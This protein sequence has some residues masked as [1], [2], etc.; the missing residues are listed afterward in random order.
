MKK[1][2]IKQVLLSIVL[3]L[4][5]MIIHAQ[6]FN[7]RGVVVDE[8]NEKLPG[9]SV[10]IKNTLKGTE[11]DFDGA[12]TLKVKKGDILSIS[13]LGY[14]TQEVV[15]TSQKELLISLKQDANVLEEVVVTALGR[16][17]KK[18]AL[19]FA[20]ATVTGENLVKT[21]EVD[22]N[23]SI[24][25]KV[26]GVQAIGSSGATFDNAN[27]RLRGN[28]NVLYVVDGVRVQ[29][30][31]DI[32]TADIEDISV[33]KGGAATALYGTDASGG[34][35][36][37]TSKKAR[38]GSKIDIQLSTEI[39]S[40]T[41]MLE[42]QN[43]YGGGYSQDFIVMPNG[44]LRPDYGADQSWGPRLDGTLV[45]HWDSW[46]E[47][48]PEFGKLRPWS[49]NPT[50]VEDFYEN[51][52]IKKAI[53]T[54]QNGGENHSISSVL[55]HVD[56]E[57]I[58]PNSG[59]KTTQVSINADY[60]VTPKLKVNANVNYQVRN[61]LNNP[62]LGYTG[63][64]SFFRPNQW[65]QRQLDMNR[66]RNY[67]RNGKFVSWNIQSPTNPI[68]AFW[69]SPY[70]EFFENRNEQDKNA[71]F[72]K[73]AL[74]YNILENLTASVQYRRTYNA[75]D[76]FRI[77][78]FGSRGGATQPRF[79]ESTSK[80]IE[81]EFFGT[82]NYNT[83]LGEEV[84]LDATVGFQIQNKKFESI[85]A[86]TVGGLTTPN[87]Y[88]IA[89]SV[90]RPTYVRNL[91][92]IKGRALFGSVT[93]SFKDML[94]IDTSLRSDWSSTANPDKN[95]VITYGVSSSFVFSE[96]LK[97]MDFLNFGKLRAGFSSAPTFP[98]AH[99]I[100]ETY[101]SAGNYNGLPLYSIPST[102][103]NPEI[104]G[105]SSKEAEFGLELK[106]FN[107]K[108]DFDLTY[109]NIVANDFPRSVS[110]PAS[111][112][113]SSVIRNSGKETR[114][115]WELGMTFRPVKTEDF[116][117]ETTVNLATIDWV[118]DEINNT[119]DPN[120]P[121]TRVLDRVWT[122]NTGY[123]NLKDVEGMPKGG[124]YGARAKR[125]D[126][127]RLIINQS[128]GDW[129][130]QLFEIENDVL[131][132]NFLPDLTG[133]FVNTFRYKDFELAASIDFQIGGEFYSTSKRWAL[134]SGQSIETVGTN[135]KGNPI[136]DAVADG[137]GIRVDGV[138]SVTGEPVTRYIG[139]YAYFDRQLPALAES[140]VYDASYVK[141]RQMSIGYTLPSKWYKKWGISNVKASIFG[142]NLWLIYAKDEIDPS[143][144]EN[145]SGTSLG[146]NGRGFRWQ[147]GAQFPSQRTIGMNVNITF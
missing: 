102:Q 15:I 23:N 45:R 17:K 63:S 125:D 64:G 84:G 72:G 87:F 67:K 57:G 139:A 9:V 43:E 138:D 141:L 35:V 29:S 80:N 100:F 78:A 77:Q 76:F 5:P 82:L 117:W 119:D 132:G 69:D 71:V 128:A 3:L 12:F 11:T 127:G 46:I 52:F 93:L 109:Y 24:A 99:Q 7:I 68:P 6:E 58:L 118:V 131:L 22:I 112:G 56:Q 121:S 140:L 113:F 8:L 66:L 47:G 2:K 103:K 59:R 60:N 135:D 40:V 107:N 27:I 65:W 10:L 62:Q 95:R 126:Q 19:G 34:V 110:L 50:N 106:M 26:S 86:S 54:F 137:G 70:F 32:N 79:E 97:D 44:Q 73:L 48:D 20:Q 31:A 30:A 1:M 105:A 114:S 37:I 49:P 51:A 25:G 98:A 122:W 81:D 101:S 129:S 145:V 104:I 108:V 146:R 142:N 38:D 74:N 130:R 36:I 94:F 147:E 144:I 136:R 92:N 124:I 39:G 143:E 89:S 14:A 116:S 33:L 18:K 91:I 4:A 41:N 134:A 21:N 42:Y 133:G 120:T 83:K 61:T 28:S 75:F 111:T 85:Y 53:F 123:V 13:Y 16:Q 115:G 88:S 90:D 55:R 96:L